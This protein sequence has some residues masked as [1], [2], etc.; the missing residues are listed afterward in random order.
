MQWGM[1][2]EFLIGNT[3]KELLTGGDPSPSKTQV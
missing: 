2:N 1:I 3:V